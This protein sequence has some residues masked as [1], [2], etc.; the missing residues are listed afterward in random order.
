MKEFITLVKTTVN[1]SKIFK[2]CK[3]EKESD[4]EIG[5][6]IVLVESEELSEK[7]SHFAVSDIFTLFLFIR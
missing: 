6:M 5:I 1:Y 2:L 7:T 3:K 4:D